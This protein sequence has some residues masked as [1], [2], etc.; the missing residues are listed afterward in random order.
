MTP[1]PLPPDPYRAILDEAYHLPLPDLQ[2][3]VWRYPEA[4]P[5]G[6][7]QVF[8]APPGT[9]DWEFVGYT[10]DPIVGVDYGAPD[11]GETALIA[12]PR[13]HGKTTAFT[14]TLDAPLTG[15][16]HT[17]FDAFLARHQAGLDRRL[18][19][20]ARDLGQWEPQVRHDFHAVQQVLE[21][22]GIGDGYGRLTIPQPVR[23]PIEPPVIRW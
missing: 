15:S 10:T 11:P 12:W 3:T 18:R 22:H 9:T 17:L 19:R 1:V 5:D 7:Q 16:V 14:W 4:L 23:P 2:A 8:V 21:A 20:L 13:Q 6:A